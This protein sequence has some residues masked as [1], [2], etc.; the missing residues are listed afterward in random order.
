MNGA[1]G[2]RIRIPEGKNL[3]EL[4]RAN[5]GIDN[6][7]KAPREIGISRD[8][9]KLVR[10]LIV[11]K[12]RQVLSREEEDLVNRSLTI[13]QSGGSFKDAAQMVDGILNRLWRKG[14]RDGQLRN[15]KPGRRVR[16]RF[17]RTLF[18][19]RE[20]CTNIEDVQVPQAI[21]RPDREDAI[22]VL[23]NSI[24]ALSNL[25]KQITKGHDHD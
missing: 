23:A 18:T 13:L 15:D 4:V 9:Y 3:E 21:T 14:T 10:N 20:V 5:M 11:L 6:V 1:P 8:L 2:P 12:D 25:L 16:D 19:I 22:Q 7:R 17:D 24:A